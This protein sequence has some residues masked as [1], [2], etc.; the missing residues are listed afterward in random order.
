MKKILIIIAATLA[1][2]LCV[3]LV[4]LSLMLSSISKSLTLANE[5]VTA[6]EAKI[7]VLNEEILKIESDNREIEQKLQSAEEGLA[8]TFT[9]IESYVDSVKAYGLTLNQVYASLSEEELIAPVCIEE[10]KL[11]YE[12]M[13][14]FNG[15]V[16]ATVH[17]DCKIPDIVNENM[18]FP[19]DYFVEDID[20]VIYNK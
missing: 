17:I 4:M 12:Y 9:V 1:L 19:G 16:Y 10:E 8:Q 3:S 11:I 7:A 18:E 20:F 15:V 6:T 13:L 5:K 14:E 2:A